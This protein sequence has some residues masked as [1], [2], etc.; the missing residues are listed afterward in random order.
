MKLKLAMA[1]V[2]SLGA[3]N[4]AQAETR[5][6]RSIAWGLAQT[7]HLIDFEAAIR[8]VHFRRDLD[9]PVQVIC[10]G[11][12]SARVALW[13]ESGSPFYAITLDGATV[14]VVTSADYVIPLLYGAFD[15]LVMAPEI[16]N[17]LQARPDTNLM[18]V[19]FVTQPINAYR[20]ALVADG[21][22][23]HQ[24]LGGYTYLVSAAQPVREQLRK[25]PYV[26]WV[27]DYHPAYRLEPF[28]YENVLTTP[29][30]STPRRYSIMMVE[31]GPLMKND[32]AAEVAAI[33][34]FVDK[35][36]PNGYLIEATLTPDQLRRI[37]AMDE[38]VYVDHWMPPVDYMDNVR[39]VGGANDVET[40]AGYTGAG[41]RGEVMDGNLR[42]THRAFSAHL[43][44]I[45]GTIS[46]DSSH[47]TPVYGIVFGDGNSNAGGRGLIPDA[48]GIFADYGSLTDRYAHTGALLASPYFAVFQTN[49]WGSCCF[50]TYTT[51]A[52]DMDLNLFDHDFLLLQAQ[53]NSGSTQSDVIAFAKNLVSVGGI[54][55]ADTATLSD[56]T[57]SAAGSIGPASDGRIKPDLCFWY[58]WIKCTANTNDTSYT[59]SFG[60][61]SAAT[62]ITAGHFG[63]FFQM[64][65]EGIFGNP[66]NPNATVFENRPHM[67]TAK[68]MMIN[69][70]TPYSFSG[71]SADL[72]RTHQGWGRPDVKHLYDLKDKMFIVNETD[73]LSN[74]EMTSYQVQVAAGEPQFR[75]TLVYTDPPGVPSSNQ[76]R[77]N[78]LSLRVTAPNATTYWGNNGMTLGNVTTPGGSENTKDTVENVW[79][80]NPAA[81]AWTVEVLASEIVQDSHV[82]T[83]AMD[84]DYAL[85]VSGIVPAPLADG[86]MN[87]DGLVDGADV[88]AFTLAALDLPAYSTTYPGCNSLHGDFSGD[89]AI[90]ADDVSGFVAALLSE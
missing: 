2:V 46:G 89:G 57:W 30:D 18:L 12:S 71:A 81:G 33:G 27:G 4:S 43:P 19:Q 50:T 24:Y 67:S 54:R 47:G 8:K 74:L 73:V 51:G 6:V 34:G 68:A 20:D 77:V 5:D 86:D 7:D 90:G 69:T 70:C 84:A 17:S 23:I 31:P 78:N 55:H 3:V 80:L 75:A 9:G 48:Q 29:G 1:V 41:V 79:V 66:V 82:E 35:N 32:V 76:H 14:D 13:T 37:V 53:A 16:D 83:P 56:D 88:T 72:T 61:T 15:P 85:V 52:A 60:G 59:T 65:A 10:P 62:P 39:T 40:V 49:S 22:Q 42:T 36:T 64:W 26:R 44:V 21:A 45:H 25:L 38:V 87:C 28:I 58:D 11:S 63:I